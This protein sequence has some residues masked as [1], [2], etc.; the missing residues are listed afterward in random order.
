MAVPDPT[1]CSREVER[2]FKVPPD[3]EQRLRALGAS[4]VSTKTF[5][6]HYYDTEDHILCQRDFWLRLRSE[7]NSWELKYRRKDDLSCGLAAAY[8]EETGN[9]RI[10]ATLRE[11]LP[12]LE[13][14]PGAKE[15]NDLVANKALREFAVIQTVR[16]TYKVPG[17]A[18]VD[19][20]ETD[21]GFAVGEIEVV[22]SETDEA[23]MPAALEKATAEIASLAAQLGVA[24]GPPAE[25]KMESYLRLQCPAL[26]RRLA[27]VIWPHSEEA[28]QEYSAALP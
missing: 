3:I 28:K 27:K 19:L 12:E 17:N 14:G 26:Y 7:K 6:D 8:R 22:L 18:L 15:V 23:S 4:H 13:L 24:E 5:V 21:W 25:G 10:L 2:K 1:Q 9:A 11:L 20:D 16:R